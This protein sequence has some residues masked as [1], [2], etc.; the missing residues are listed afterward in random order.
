MVNK[1]DCNNWFP[2]LNSTIEGGAI[3]T[4]GTAE[5]AKEEAHKYGWGNKI[6]KIERRLENV[7]I[8]GVMDFQTTEICGVVNDTL[9]IPLLRWE[10]GINGITYNPVVIFRRPQATDNR[11]EQE[12]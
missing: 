8:V 3:R 9:R 10:K 5:M 2:N 7:Y 12:Q 6:L 11:K 4:F 1:I